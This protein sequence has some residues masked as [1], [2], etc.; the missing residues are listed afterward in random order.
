MICNWCDNEYDPG[1]T[2]I[3]CPAHEEGGHLSC[4]WKHFADE[5]EED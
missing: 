3:Y 2:G 1:E 4:G 5:H